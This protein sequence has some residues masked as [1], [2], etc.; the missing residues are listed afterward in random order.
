MLL[1]RER[2]HPGKQQRTDRHPVCA[3]RFVASPIRNLPRVPMTN[4]ISSVAFKCAMFENKFRCTSPLDGHFKSM[5]RRTR[6][7]I[8]EISCAPLVSIKTVKPSLQSDCISGKE[9][10]CRNGSP[11]VSSTSGSF[12]FRILNFELENGAASSS[13]FCQNFRQR[14][15]F[16]FSESISRVAIR[17]AQVAR[18][19]PDENA[20]QAGKG[21]F[22]LQ[23]QID[24][25]DDERVGHRAKISRN[26]RIRQNF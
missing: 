3:R 11:P 9:F 2:M 4:L 5:M 7:S 13:N 18:G 10:F 19:E 23:A 6:G 14:F 22:A 25:V 24:F 1:R 12:E 15:F 16:A 20:R 26:R 8:F 21:A 17:A